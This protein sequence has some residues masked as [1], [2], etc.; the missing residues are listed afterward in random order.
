L[1]TAWARA[2]LVVAAGET[3]SVE[4]DADDPAIWVHPIDPALSLIIG[5][6]KD[7]GLGTWDVN[8][9]PIQF[10]AIGEPNNVGVRYGFR[11]DGEL[12]DIAVTDNRVSHRLEVFRVDVAARRLVPVSGEGIV[13]GLSETYGLCLYRSAVSGKH[14]VFVNDKDGDFEQW[15]M[16]DEGGTV[17][18]RLARTFDVGAR[19]EGCVADDVAG[20]LFVSAE[21]RALWKYGAEPGDR[22]PPLLIDTSKVEDLTGG[23]LIPEIEGLA[24]Y[25]GPQGTGYLIASSQGSDDFTVYARQ[26]PHT[27]YGRFR[28]IA[29]A[30]SDRVTHTDGIDLTNVPLG[31]RFPNGLFV[32]HDAFDENPY[33]NFKLVPWENIARAFDPPLLVDPRSYHPRT[34][35]ARAP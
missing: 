1:A 30:G 23:H 25:Y 34:V 19:T 15:E 14:Y 21:R 7:N 12:V 20:A 18:G 22:A 16:V 32:A 28:I 35:V 8:G 3:T 27:Y 24:L 29:E 31:P 33:N 6:D 2:R 11:L 5:T 9:R 13:S 26:P 4:G 17:R 10:M